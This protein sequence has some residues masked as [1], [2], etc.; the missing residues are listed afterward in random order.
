LKSL[1]VV[2]IIG[3]VI[4]AVNGDTG[5]PPFGGS[6]V[7]SGQVDSPPDEGAF[8][9]VVKP[10]GLAL[11]DEAQAQR[12]VP[13]FVAP[14]QTQT[15][16]IVAPAHS[17]M[18]GRRSYSFMVDRRETD[19]SKQQ[20]WWPSDGIHAGYDGRW[21]PRVA[22]DPRGRRAGMLFP[23]FA[24]LFVRALQQELSK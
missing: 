19:P 7:A 6:P 2:G 22:N 21:G 1:S 9:V 24:Q 8:G 17:M 13:W 16:A 14:G 10:H 15:P 23:N 20:V 5:G 12:V 3:I 11:P 18:I 4:E